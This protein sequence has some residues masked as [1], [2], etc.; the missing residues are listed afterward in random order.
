MSKNCTRT[1]SWASQQKWEEHLE[2]VMSHPKSEQF[3]AHAKGEVKVL[4][5]RKLKTGEWNFPVATT[6]LE[7][8]RNF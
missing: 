8:I 1:R 5:Q 3:R 7:S 4:L 6:R 2:E